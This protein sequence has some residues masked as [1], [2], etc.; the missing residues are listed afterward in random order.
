M[1][2]A[3][4]R[5][6]TPLQ[7]GI[8]S[9][10]IHSQGVNY[11]NHL[12]LKL[13]NHVIVERVQRA[14]SLVVDNHEMLRT[15]FGHV[16][17]NQYPL[18]MITYRAQ[19][20]ELPIQEIPNWS[21]DFSQ[22]LC[23]WQQDI[24]R[25]LQRPA[26]RMGVEK[27][28]TRARIHLVIHHALYDASS[29][30][31]IL[32]DLEVAYED[33]E[34]LVAPSLDLIIAHFLGT[35]YMTKSEYIHFWQEKSRDICINRFP[36][37]TPVKAIPCSHQSVSMRCK[38]ARQ[39]IDVGCTSNDIPLQVLGQAAWAKVLA[40][41]IGEDD[42]IFGTVYGGR[43]IEGAEDVPFPCITTL[44]TLANVANGAQSLFTSLKEFNAS[45]QNYGFVP[46]KQIQRW[47]GRDQEPLF[48]TIFA[49][50]NLVARQETSKLWTIEAE[51]VSVEARILFLVP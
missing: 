15:G 6:C 7:A 4:V 27:S 22:S 38:T 10:H 46:L 50:Q 39:E 48:D 11:V 34:V 18:V 33:A 35:D 2:I 21:N 12:I 20:M 26:W 28:G 23:E 8:V 16:K 13:S 36:T 43:L 32:K 3:C 42:V 24:L 45:V 29:L 49:C 40:A 31:M 47:V 19:A 51:E 9:E 30:G 5:P 41:Y 25:S 14:W 1:D 44:P 37:L 17:D